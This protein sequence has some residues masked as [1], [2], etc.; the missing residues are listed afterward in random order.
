M[1]Q[2]V[3]QRWGA[4][5]HYRVGCGGRHFRGPGTSAT[6]D[7]RGALTDR[8]CASAEDFGGVGLT[9]TIATADRRTS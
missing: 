7:R 3:V 5:N 4:G 9:G 2:T 8:R 6:A 1:G